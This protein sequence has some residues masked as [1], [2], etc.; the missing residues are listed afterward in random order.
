MSI[1]IAIIG[2]SA[3]ILIHELGHYWMARLLKVPVVSFSIGFGPLIYKRYNS[4]GTSFTLRAILLG[5]YVKFLEVDIPEHNLKMYDSHPLW[6]RTLIVLAG[7]FA[8][9]LCAYVLFI[10]IGLVG[11][12]GLKPQ[13]G[14]I[15]A[16]SPA[17]QANIK[18]GDTIVSINNRPIYIWQDFVWHSLASTGEQQIPIKVRTTDGGE[19]VTAINL[20]QQNL[21]DIE[22][23]G[24]EQTIGISPRVFELPPIIG[25]VVE[26]SAAQTAGFNGGDEVLAVD[27]EEIDTWQQLSQQIKAS[28]NQELLIS[29]N[30]NGRTLEILLTP[31]PSP[32]DASIGL[33]G[34]SAQAPND[35]EYIYQEYYTEVTYPLGQV[36][37]Y[38]AYQS[39]LTLKLTVS[40]LYQLLVGVLGIES[41]GGPVRIVQFVGLSFES[42]IQTF[43]QMLAFINLSLFFFNLLP[44]PILDGGHLTLYLF[45]AIRRKKPSMKFITNYQK[46]GFFL[47][48]TL[49]IFVTINDLTR[50]L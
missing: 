41:L 27:G 32:Q 2:L 36:W 7:P 3:L 46:L 9:L 17:A 13:V 40:S 19:I 37:Q 39:Y 11:V 26:S 49:F 22:E 50:V 21:G 48:I 18:Q 30:R 20:E 10:V 31:A 8:N 42:G 24:I 43:I 23:R 16:N 28:V 15:I 6:K 1:L 5:G 4:F 33:A 35:T 34:M 29:I 38:A 12:T 45:E 47:M 44:I 25:Q 14:E